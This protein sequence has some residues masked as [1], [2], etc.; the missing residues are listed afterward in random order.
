MNRCD[1]FHEEVFQSYVFDI[2]TEC[3]GDLTPSL[4]ILIYYDVWINI[5]ICLAQNQLKI[6]DFAVSSLKSGLCAK[7]D[8]IITTGLIL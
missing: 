7:K 3:L 6:N 8:N 2:I 4:L 1:N 5:L